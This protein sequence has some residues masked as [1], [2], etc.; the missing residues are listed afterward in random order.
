MFAPV[1]TLVGPV[2]F[3]VRS[4][5]VPPPLVPWTRVC[6]D[7]VVVKFWADFVPDTEAVLFRFVPLA[8]VTWPR[9]VIVT[10]AVPAIVPIWQVTVF[11]FAPP[12]LQGPCVLVIVSWG[13]PGG[14]WT[15]PTPLTWS[16]M[17]TVSTL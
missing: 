6:T 14:L 1:S 12:W 2:L 8:A 15:V 9:I 13:R 10:V 17:T 4:G 5:A 7:A 3:R 16:V 11:P